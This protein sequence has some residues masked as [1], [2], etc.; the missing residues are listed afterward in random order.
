MILPRSLQTIIEHSQSSEGDDM[1]PGHHQDRLHP[2]DAAA[3]TLV[4]GKFVTYRP[5]VEGAQDVADAFEAAYEAIVA[6][7]A[8]TAASIA[9]DNVV[10]G[11]TGSAPP[12][13]TEIVADTIDTMVP[14]MAKIVTD[15]IRALSPATKPAHPAVA[16]DLANTIDT[17]VPSVTN[18][19]TDLIRALTPLLDADTSD[20]HKHLHPRRAE[21]PV[22]DDCTPRPL[23]TPH[24]FTLF[25]QDQH[26]LPGR[27]LTTTE[28]ANLWEAMC[29][30]WWATHP[31][32]VCGGPCSRVLEGEWK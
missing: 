5:F 27:D 6:Q 3:A 2:R 30:E 25:M 13:E 32:L 21:V 24:E 20:D 16:D 14:T 8:T 12:P 4:S 10:A 28:L 15:L 26:F 23:V 17:V 31:Q 9:I 7:V 18:V 1:V 29:V 11:F 19:V 22:T